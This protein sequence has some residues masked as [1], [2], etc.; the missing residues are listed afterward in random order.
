MSEPVSK[1]QSVSLLEKIPE[2]VDS[3]IKNEVGRV[4]LER[5]WR[6]INAIF[7]P[8]FERR[9]KEMCQDP[10]KL[11]CHIVIP[12]V[13][14]FE[15]MKDLFSST[16]LAFHS[17]TPYHPKTEENII[18]NIFEEFARESLY[19][20]TFEYRGHPPRLYD[21]A[22][23]TQKVGLSDTPKV[24]TTFSKDENREISTSVE[25]MCQRLYLIS[26]KLYKEITQRVVTNYLRFLSEEK[27]FLAPV[28]QKSD[29]ILLDIY[30]RTLPYIR[31]NER[32]R[33]FTFA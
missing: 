22:L 20:V 14:N 15:I 23:L 30:Q 13:Y 9:T 3:I 7:L 1:E 33:L 25:E 2:G 32:T 8:S 31:Y 19:V 28:D 16:G 11:Y 29:H 6:M 21:H 27:S 4:H 26:L 10:I 24:V 17:I 5:F 12:S 18:E